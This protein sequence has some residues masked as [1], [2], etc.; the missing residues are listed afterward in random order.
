MVERWEGVARRPERAAD[1]VEP[2]GDGSLA[3]VCEL[4]RRAFD[5]DRSALLG[6]LAE[7]AHA[8]P[9]VARGEGG[10]VVGYAFARSG[11][12]AAYAG[13]VV[14]SDAASAEALVDALFGELD[15]QRVYVDVDTR[16][17]GAT[18]LLARRGFR[19]QRELIRMRRGRAPRHEAARMVFAIAGPEVG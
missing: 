12:D 2:A 15:G 1:G 9:L 18:S 19:K 17:A 16:F 14:A 3:D 6:A 11:A 7:A 13:P 5:A 10:A 4:D 8:T